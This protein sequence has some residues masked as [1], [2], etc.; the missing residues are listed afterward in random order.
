MT[1]RVF[2]IGTALTAFLSWAIW[3]LIVNYLDP[4]RAGWLGFLLFFLA[5]FL[6]I[7]SVASLIGFF[8]RRLVMPQR[9]PSYAVRTAL[10][11][12]VLLGLFL[13]LLLF[14]QLIR[15]YQ[16]WLAI[17]GICLFL[18]IEFIFLGYDRAAR[19]TTHPD[20]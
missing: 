8:A 16:W 3:L 7:A 20:S 18:F 10:R 15:L 14:L 9:L 6:A 2:T 11:Q 17:F 5:L 19:R 13:D 4:T 12:G 1:V